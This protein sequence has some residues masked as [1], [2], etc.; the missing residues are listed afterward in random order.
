MSYDLTVICFRVLYFSI[1][2]Y[3]HGAFWPELRESDYDFV[4]SGKGKGYNIN[5]PLN[6]VK[7]LSFRI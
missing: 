6:K 7:E 4:G 3:D 2:R 1:H 5:V